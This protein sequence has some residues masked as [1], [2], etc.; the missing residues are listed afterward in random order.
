MAFEN[1]A[2]I[3]PLHA[4]IGVFRSPSAAANTAN[5]AATTTFNYT[6]LLL[7][8]LNDEIPASK[9]SMM[10]EMTR[11]E[12]DAK[13]DRV[14]ARAETRFVE[15]SG[16]IDRLSDL[17]T[18]MTTNVGNQIAGVR[19]ELVAVQADNKFTRLTIVVAVVASVLAGL[20]SLWVTQSNL[21]AAFQTG[22][23]LRPETKTETKEVPP[24][25]PPPSKR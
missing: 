1:R 23:A 13:L 4:G 7:P 10:S 6:E 18:S 12:I 14:E 17:V 8:F 9:E 19:S 21:L 20:G 11:E 25:T 3:V 16:K 5:V 15:L 2:Q 22:I 24:P